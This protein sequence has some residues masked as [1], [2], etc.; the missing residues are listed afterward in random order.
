MPKSKRLPTSSLT[1][2]TI[3]QKHEWNRILDH[4]HDYLK[5][6]DGEEI[7]DRLQALTNNVNARQTSR[8]LFLSATEKRAL[9]FIS[10]Q[11]KG[12]H[13]PSVR[14]VATAVGYTSSRS[15]LR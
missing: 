8:E 13:P 7:L 2:L 15:G 14:D 12:G 4:L 10:N 6:S 3:K 11:I 5:T 9:T 1:D